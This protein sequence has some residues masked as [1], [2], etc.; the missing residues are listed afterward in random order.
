MNKLTVTW[1]GPKRVL[2]VTTA[3]AAIFQNL[4]NAKETNFYVARLKFY[5]SATLDVTEDLKGHITY[6][7]KSLYLVE[8]FSEV[9]RSSL[10]KFDVLVSW[11]GFSGENI[12][13]ELKVLAAD[14]PVRLLE[15]F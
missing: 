8:E 3:L 15:F 5:K 7:Q 1:T 2:R 12:C 9:R 13:E 4:V 6:R 10:R 14:V 11:V